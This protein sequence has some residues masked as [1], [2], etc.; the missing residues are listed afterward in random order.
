MKR[1]SRFHLVLLLIVTCIANASRE[2][3]NG[4]LITQLSVKLPWRVGAIEKLREFVEPVDEA[5]GKVTVELRLED[6]FKEAGAIDRALEQLSQLASVARRNR[7]AVAVSVDLDNLP[8]ACG[9]D[10]PMRSLAVSGRT[11]G[12]PSPFAPNAIQA[13][14]KAFKTLSR[15]L[16]GQIDALVLRVPQLDPQ[17]LK[18]NDIDWHMPYDLWCGDEFARIA[19]RD[20]VRSKYVTLSALRGAWGVEL[21][22]WEDVTYPMQRS[23]EDWVSLPAG[24]RRHWLDFV[25]W[26][27]D[28]VSNFIGGLARQARMAFPQVRLT[29]ELPLRATPLIGW[30]VSALVREASIDSDT[31]FRVDASAPLLCLALLSKAC[32]FYKVEVACNL[33]LSDEKAK[34]GNLMLQGSNAI[35]FQVFAIALLQPEALALTLDELPRFLRMCE[36]GELLIPRRH[37]T[38][39]AVLLPSTSISLSPP[40]L[41]EFGERLN[42]IVDVVPCDLIDETLLLGG[43]CEDYRVLIAPAGSVFCHAS[44]ESMMSWIERGGIL[45]IGSNEMWADVSGKCEVGKRI[46]IE[47]RGDETRLAKLL[48]GFKRAIDV[49]LD[50]MKDTYTALIK[51]FGNGFILWFPIGELR[52]SLNA[53]ALVASDLAF[54]VSKCASTVG[55]AISPFHIW[56]PMMGLSGID[57]VLFLW[58]DGVVTLFNA[59]PQTQTITIQTHAGDEKRTLA[60][61]ETSFVFVRDSNT[62]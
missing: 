6:G 11:S 14:A 23:E 53:F 47:H 49:P 35:G 62:P 7:F 32:D 3:T 56:Q 5:L 42:A 52:E 48:S 4:K 15:H 33:R 58:H 1:N 45:L 21:K 51:R 10:M 57:G 17:P 41:S 55:R 31:S 59:S 25:S 9:I 34:K 44:L 61:C 36:D 8:R 43:A 40:T 2:Q 24:M 29:L 13:Y 19:F 18:G 20:H 22:R 12:A 60:S 30:Q 54:D 37:V 46:G 39:V 26:Y 16:K 50:A 38:D 28:A 27:C